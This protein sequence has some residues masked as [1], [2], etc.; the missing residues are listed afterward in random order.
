MRF[1]ALA[2]TSVAS[3]VLAFALFLAAWLGGGGEVDV[4]WAPT[5]GLRLDLA[6]DGLGALYAL[7]ATGIGDNAGITFVPGAGHAMHAGNPSYYN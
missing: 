7:L 4:D 5:L 2:W 3:A 6:L 1:R